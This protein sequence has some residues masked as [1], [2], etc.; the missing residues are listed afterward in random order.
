[1]IPAWLVV[2]LVLGF[3]FC[4]WGVIGLLRLA[5]SFADRF[6][7]SPRVAGS[8]AHRR[9]RAETSARV[10]RGPLEPGRVSRAQVAVIMAAH[11]EEVVIRESLTEV[12]RLVSPEQVHV[13]SDGSSDATVAIARSCGVHVIE[14]PTNVGKAGALEFGI[15][16]FGLMHRFKAVLLLDADTRLDPD[17]FRQALPLFDDPSVGAVAGFAASDWRRADRSVVG[18]LLVAHR[19][20][21]YEL[22][23][24]LM[25][26]GQTWRYV[27][28]THIV[29]GFA[30]MYRTEVLD[31]IDI[32]PGGL[33]IED[34]NMTFELQRKKLGTVG[35]S[36]RAVAVTQDP[37]RF[38]DYWRQM[39]RWALGLWQTVRRHG[40]RFDRLTAML[41]LLLGELISASVFLLF[42]PVL[43]IALAVA[44][45]FPWVLDNGTY[46][47]V[48]QILVG[49]VTGWLLVGL[50][51]VP[52]LVLTLVVMVLSRRV[53]YAW[54][55]WGYL[56]MRLV[57]AFIALQTMIKARSASTGRWV[58]PT[59]RALADPGAGE[60]VKAAAAG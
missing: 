23:Q 46:A 13:V 2:V 48:H 53:S 60:P 25:K 27:H 14:T 4:V 17:Y 15:R 43:V 9:W 52:D 24:R 45:A 51:L 11:N 40:P 47:T 54:F 10:A 19:S 55:A 49:D 56:P 29:P 3:N 34:F 50:V 20:R 36:P 22:T 38:S 5:D 59:R 35:F 58:S 1:M 37:N 41:I 21:V 18:G 44:A 31:H 28:V 30:S 33:V 8:R 7:S 12:C 39:N 26:Y 32:N 57:D 6:R 42:L 16:E